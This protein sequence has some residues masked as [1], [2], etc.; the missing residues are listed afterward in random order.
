MLKK[1]QNLLFEEEEAE[2]IEEEEVE[3]IPEPAPKRRRETYAEPAKPE[4]KQ[5][6]Q[7]TSMQRIDVTQPLQKITDAL[8][9]DQG[10]VFKPA[11]NTYTQP[12]SEKPKGLGLTVD[13]LAGSAQK[14]QPE[15]AKKPAPQQSRTSARQKKSSY[16]FQPVISPFFGVDDKEP[17]LV[18]TTGSSGRG[19]KAEEGSP[20]ISPINGIVKTS[21]EEEPVPALRPAAAPQRPGRTEA[22]KPEPEPEEKDDIPEFSL[23]D[24]LKV[25]DE[26]YARDNRMVMQSLFPDLDGTDETEIP[27]ETTVL[28][29]RNITPYGMLGRKQ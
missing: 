16:D 28:D 2:E 22:R 10:S 7:R 20:L 6:E 3:E 13:E 1:L 17:N 29:S 27:D 14:P 11:E 15:P 4:P 19:S 12:E 21:K 24:I 25:R 5:E 23:D 9:Q 18:H 26:E 8:P